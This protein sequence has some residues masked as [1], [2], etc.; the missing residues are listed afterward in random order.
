MRG[1]G[2]KKKRERKGFVCKGARLKECALRDWGD[3]TKG[4]EREKEE[5]EG[6]YGSA[7]GVKEW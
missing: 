1:K 6:K 5:E 3:E 7:V 4:E 2:K